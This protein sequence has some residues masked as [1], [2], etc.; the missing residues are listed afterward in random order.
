[1]PRKPKIEKETME[2]VEQAKA[3]A[4]EIIEEAKRR[5]KEL[6]AT[7]Q[8]PAAKVVY[9]CV[10][11]L[12]EIEHP[13]DSFPEGWKADGSREYDRLVFYCPDCTD[14]HPEAS[15]LW[16]CENCGESIED[17]QM[18]TGWIAG[19]DGG[20]SCPKCNEAAQE[21]PRVACKGC[22]QFIYPPDNSTDPIWLE[23]EGKLSCT[24]CTEQAKIMP[25]ITKE[26]N[27]PE[28]PVEAWKNYQCA[29]CQRS[30]LHQGLPTDWEY[31]EKFTLCN[32]CKEKP[33]ETILERRRRLSDRRHA[34]HAARAQGEAIRIIHGAA[35]ELE[36]SITAIKA[37]ISKLE[38]QLSELV[39]RQGT[40]TAAG[41]RAYTAYRKHCELH[42][43]P[44]EV[45]NLFAEQAEIEFE[46]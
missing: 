32:T 37:K 36:N 8:P 10:D 16:Y 41:E 9:E 20:Y 3:S 27:Q 31:K 21:I 35:K 44:D 25:S 30:T 14:N 28:K 42:S 39:Y 12:K 33:L 46:D 40:T 1:M 26:N 29:G 7:M 11:C 18:P 43:L 24:K 45:S 6:Q 19:I 23:N 34:E 17:Q 5:R 38:G 13:A 4:V 15:C 22:G 2:S